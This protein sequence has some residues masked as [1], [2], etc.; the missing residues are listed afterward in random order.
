[1][2]KPKRWANAV[3]AAD[4]AMEE[5]K[6]IQSEYQDWRD[7]MPENLESSPLVEKLDVVCEIDFDSIQYDIQ[8]AGDA[9]LPLG[10][11]RD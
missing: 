6:D 3:E 10:F 11:G 1:M 4:A 7:N 8:E 9:D 2:S 5:L